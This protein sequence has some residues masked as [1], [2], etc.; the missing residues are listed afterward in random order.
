MLMQE[1]VHLQ[2]VQQNKNKHV[3]MYV[4]WSKY[5]K[6]NGQADAFLEN[7]VFF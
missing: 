1:V 7:V 5:V 3:N 6:I 2:E 4:F